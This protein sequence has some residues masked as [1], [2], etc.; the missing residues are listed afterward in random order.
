EF[1]AHTPY[2]YSTYEDEDEVADSDKPK[3]LILGSGPNRIG[4]GIEFDYCCVQAAFALRE[5]GHRVIMVNCNPETVSTDYDIS[6]RLYF[7]PLTFEDVKAIVEKERPD[8]ILVQYGGQTPLKLARRL[9]EIGARIIGTSPDAIDRCEDRD[10]FGRLLTRLGMRQPNS[11]IA[12]TAAEARREA[13]RVGYPVLL[14]PSYVLGGRGM[15]VVRDEAALERILGT[16][17]RVSEEGPVL[18]DEFLEG[19]TEFDV[20]AI[21][22]GERVVIGAIMQHIEEAGIHSGDS[23]CILPP[24]DLD[25]RIEAVL[26]QQTRRLGTELGVR[27]LMNVQFAVRGEKVYVLEVNPRA[28]RT[29]PFVSKA[30]GVPLARLGAQVM[31]GRT[32]A[33]LGL[34]SDPGPLAV[35]VKAPVFPFDRFPGADPVLGPEML[36]TGEVI[37]LAEDAPT[38]YLKAMLG[39]GVDLAD[40]VRRGVLLSLNDRDK[41]GGAEVAARLA[42]MDIRLYATQG[43]RD[44]LEARGIQAG[45]ILKV[46]EG[47]PDAVDLIRGGEVGLVI[48]TPLGRASPFDEFALRRAALVAGIPCLTTLS[49]ARFAIDAV[50]TAPGRPDVRSLQ[51]WMAQVVG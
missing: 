13:A 44:S 34:V 17:L 31:V 25:P 32:L 24:P 50:Q 8:G 27:G 40:A 28:S 4:Q 21:A 36:S 2:H 26:R 33:E 46:G 47:K 39:A 16:V 7:E 51:G 42:R 37:G 14:R 29:I 48:N 43:T 20:D 11:G 5:I 35:A 41:A 30:V 9:D 12:R 19:A 23:T 22:D 6:D 18:I 10:R 1:V 49:A 3:A 15:V 45:L 38:A